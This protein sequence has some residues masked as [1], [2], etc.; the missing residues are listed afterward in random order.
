MCLDTVTTPKKLKSEGTGY[1]VL[2]KSRRGMLYFCYFMDKEI[3][4]PIKKWINEK[5]YRLKQYKRHETI[6]PYGACYPM[7]FH[8]YRNKGDAKKSVCF[9][10][11]VIVPV[12]FRQA[13][14]TGK[15]SGKNIVVAKEIFIPK[16]A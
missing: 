10:S 13:H 16:E 1:K 14:T 2:Y 6:S 5:D 3:P 4:L 12:K 11:D 7:G 9:D 15:Q 8:I